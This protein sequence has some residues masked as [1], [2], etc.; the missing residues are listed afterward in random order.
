M[1]ESAREVIKRSLPIG[2]TEWE[3]E[4]NADRILKALTDALRDPDE[5]T[6]EAVS[7]AIAAT[8][9]VTNEG[10]WRDT[11]ARV[12]IAALADHLLGREDD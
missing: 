1:A 3:N 12:A 11:A 9:A 4:Y 2:L 6:I 10:R 7:T 8:F 5:A